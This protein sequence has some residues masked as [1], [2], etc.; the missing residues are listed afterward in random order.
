MWRPSGESSPVH[1]FGGH[2]LAGFQHAE[3]SQGECDNGRNP[4]RRPAHRSP[5]YPGHAYSP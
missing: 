3:S 1:P 5:G 2:A 4:Q